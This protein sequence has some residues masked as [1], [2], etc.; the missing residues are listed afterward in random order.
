MY[1]YQIQPEDTLLFRLKGLP[2]RAKALNLLTN[3][4]CKELE[5]EGGEKITPP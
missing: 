1:T 4:L 3:R 2:S 5:W